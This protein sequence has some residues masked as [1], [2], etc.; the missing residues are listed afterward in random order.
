MPQN[1]MLT[2]L[3]ESEVWNGE[4]WDWRMRQGLDLRGPW[5][6]LKELV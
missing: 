1:F 6:L 2:Y 5:I 4:E 3:Q